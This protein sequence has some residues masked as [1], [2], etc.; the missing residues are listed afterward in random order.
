MATGHKTLKSLLLTIFVTISLAQFTGCSNTSDVDNSNVPASEDSGVA[1][2]KIDGIAAERYDE[3]SLPA[4]EQPLSTD[5]R[6]RF[7]D[8]GQG[9]CALISCDGKNLLI[10]GGPSSASSKVYTI[11]QE[12]GIAYLDGIIVTHPDADHCGGV[13]GALN[14][15]K[16]GTFYCSTATYDTKTFNSVLKYLGDTPVTVPR[17]NDSFSLGGAIVTFVGPIAKGNADANNSSLVCRIDY[18]STSFLFTGDA[19]AES[20][21]AMA[22]AGE[23]LD[24]D[25][26][27]VG[28]HGSAS[29]S[30]SRFLSEVTPQYAIIS[31][32]KNSYGHPTSEALSRLAS[33]GAEILR[34]DELGNIIA[35]SNGVDIEVT[36]TKE[37]LIE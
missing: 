8:V 23:P 13:A 30:G 36:S 25:V 6:V 10:D 5:L 1:A 32:G 16:C 9:D 33:A 4:A 18:G 19:E 37:M 15:A 7:I 17:P 21:N 11:L 2:V 14:Y 35:V 28:H 24:A 22:S 26:L 34:T 31:A 29:S 12:L 20:E 27:K 3:P